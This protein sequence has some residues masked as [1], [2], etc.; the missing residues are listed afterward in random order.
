MR[1]FKREVSKNI[2][3]LLLACSLAVPMI[4]VAG[5]CGGSSSSPEEN[6][7]T[8]QIKPG[9]E[10]K[11]L[12]LT[13]IHLTGATQDVESDPDLGYNDRKYGTSAYQRDLFTLE[14]LDTLIKETKPDFIAVTGDL[15]YVKAQLTTD[16]LWA[17]KYGENDHPTTIGHNDN[18][19]PI[20]RF[21]DAIESYNIPWAFVYG[22][23]DAE[24]KHGREELGDYFEKRKNCLFKKGPADVYGV[25]NY[26]INVEN[27]DGTLNKALVFIDSNSYVKGKEGQAS[28]Y[29]DYIHE[30]QGEW[31]ENV[32]KDVANK[33]GYTGEVMPDSFCFFHIPL[34]E[35]QTAWDLYKAGR[36]NVK[37]VTGIN[38]ED[39]CHPFVGTTDEG[40]SYDGGKIFDRMV[41][42]GSTKAIFAGHD[43]IN[44][45]DIIYKGI[46]LIYGRSIDYTAY[47]GLVETDNS[48]GATLIHIK[49]GGEWTVEQIP[50]HGNLYQKFLAE[51]GLVGY[52]RTDADVKNDPQYSTKGEIYKSPEAAK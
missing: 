40:V 15:A 51:K 47:P 52:P 20:Q 11:V 9:G 2:V 1:L 39:V 21:V 24:G 32:L 7:H 16:G 22:N 31:Y 28:S 23:H 5:G 46:H 36:P 45:S 18:L 48:R 37:Y 35:F 3:A 17:K 41:A 33:Y 10:L 44:N 6:Y 12:Q 49:D 19:R 34:V 26:V 50:Y 4:C 30:N 38:E 27:S 25:G 8:F 13:D 43:H 42:L 14:T 29:Y